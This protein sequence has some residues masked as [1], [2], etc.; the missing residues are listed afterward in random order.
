MGI[1]S[2]N[3]VFEYFVIL[4]DAPGWVRTNNIKSNSLTLLPT[5][6]REQK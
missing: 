4:K 6:P 2:Y 1:Y 5:E 3:K